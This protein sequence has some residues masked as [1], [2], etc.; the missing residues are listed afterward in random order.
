[1]QKM[2]QTTLYT[3]ILLLAL[4]V[5]V[6]LN[7]CAILAGER[8]PLTLDLTENQLYQLSPV[9]ERVCSELQQPT[10]IHVFSARQDYPAMFGEILDRYGKMSPLLTVTYT[11]PM[12]N[13]LLLSHYQQMGFHTSAADIVVDGSA[14]SKSIP[15]Q[16]LL[17]YDGQTLTGIDIE[18]QLTSAILYANSQQTARAL[19]VAGHG[20]QAS[21]SLQNLFQTNS[22][23][24]GTA[25]LGIDSLAE[26]AFVILCGPAHDYTDAELTVL[27]NYLQEGGNLLAF[28]GPS[29]NPFPKL[30]TFLEKWGLGLSDQLVFEAR[31]YVSANPHNIIP[32]Y[33]SHEINA[34]FEDHPTY[35][36]MPGT[37]ALQLPKPPIGAKVSEVLRSTPDA[38][39]KTEL[40]FTD[41]ARTPADSPGPFTLAALSQRIFETESENLTGNVLL[42]GSSLVTADD[43]MRM[44]TYANRMFLTQVI[45]SLWQEGESIS[46]PAKTLTLSPIAITYRSALTLGIILSLVLPLLVLG[47]GALTVARRRYL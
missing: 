20:E 28:I 35:L 36:A 21:E 18:Q 19:F 41:P 10:T 29:V 3:W 6:L 27:E 5:F 46:I 42:L 1:M 31:A 23:E 8:F 12:D 2:K 13:P 34:Y 38:Y 30:N 44:T 26:A 39:A 25:V 43:L 16:D 24:T 22:F 37:R 4:F 11:D 32:M 14:R 47:A 17:Q 9:T 15:Y 40:T 45:N 33:S 7:V